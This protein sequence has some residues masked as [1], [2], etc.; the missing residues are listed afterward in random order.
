MTKTETKEFIDE[1]MGFDKK[2]KLS[3]EI[4]NTFNIRKKKFDKDMTIGLHTSVLLI[5]LKP[6]KY[7]EEFAKKHTGNKF[8]VIQFEDYPN[9]QNYLFFV[10]DGQSKETENDL[11]FNAVKNWIVG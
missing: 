9:T 11:L 7:V 5:S 2:S 1:L 4:L 8:G 6:M 10:E 3:D